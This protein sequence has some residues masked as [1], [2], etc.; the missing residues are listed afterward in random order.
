MLHMLMCVLNIYI[1]NCRPI[2]Y[3][4]NISY[5]F[6]NHAFF[7]ARLLSFQV[8]DTRSCVVHSLFSFHHDSRRIVFNDNARENT[9]TIWMYYLCKE[10]RISIV[11]SNRR[12]RGEDK[13]NLQKELVR[14]RSKQIHQLAN[15]NSLFWGMH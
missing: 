13:K 5:F 1:W 9:S 2:Q 12:N 4:S 11:E 10:L 15:E 14:I 8:R 6:T 7:S 3:T